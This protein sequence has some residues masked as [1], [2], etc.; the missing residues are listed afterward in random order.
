[1]HIF[2]VGIHDTAVTKTKKFDIILDVK[3]IVH[4]K[5]SILSLITHRHV[6]PNP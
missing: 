3:G 2:K 4:P 1:M 6:V 5:M